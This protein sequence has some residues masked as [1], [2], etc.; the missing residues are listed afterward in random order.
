M[1]RRVLTTFLGLSLVAVVF[2]GSTA[3]A[4]PGTLTL[5]H[6]TGVATW[7]AV[8]A[9]HP[10]D[11]V[12]VVV[13]ITQ[14]SRDATAI[15]RFICPDA[16]EYEVVAA[17]IGEENDR[18]RPGPTDVHV[19]RTDYTFDEWDEPGEVVTTESHSHVKLSPHAT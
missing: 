17:T 8:V 7:S 3:G 2:D 14:A 9:C 10:G 1:L 4:S 19:V 6:R 15:S 16:A 12:E 13:Y 5:D 11:E 18:L